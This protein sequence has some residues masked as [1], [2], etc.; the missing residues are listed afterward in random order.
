M[1]ETPRPDDARPTP[2]LWQRLKLPANCRDV[3]AERA[4]TTYALVGLPLGIYPA[5]V[6][7]PARANRGAVWPGEG[8][9]PPGTPAQSGREGSGRAFW[10]WGLSR[11]P[12]PVPSPQA[13]ISGNETGTETGSPPQPHG[14]LPKVPILSGLVGEPG[15]GRTSDLLIKSQLLYR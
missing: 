7:P 12:R 8:F 13:V 14:L 11:C 10:G 1:D 9:C 3:T 4:G 5:R 15:W 2:T 6:N